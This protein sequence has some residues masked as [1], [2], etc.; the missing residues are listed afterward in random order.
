[1]LKDKSGRS[2]NNV[3]FR[4]ARES[5]GLYRSQLARMSG[6]SAEK[7]ERI[8]SALAAPSESELAAMADAMNF[9]VSIFF[10]PEKNY[11]IGRFSLLEMMAK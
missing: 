2:F 7:I 9:P 4:L 1:M 5:R 3:I 10:R 8:E 11:R 6:V